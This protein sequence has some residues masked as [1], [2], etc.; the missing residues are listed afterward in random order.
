MKKKILLVIL[1]LILVASVIGA[2]KHD[3][4]QDI[5][6]NMQTQNISVNIGE[7][8]QLQNNLGNAVIWSS[9]NDVIVSVTDGGQIKGNK[10]GEA[11]VFATAGEKKVVYFVSVINNYSVSLAEVNL[12]INEDVVLSLNNNGA[13]L[14]NCLW[15]VADTAVATIDTQGKLTGRRDGTTEVLCSYQTMQFSI[16]VAVSSIQVLVPNFNILDKN[17]TVKTDNEIDLEYSLTYLDEPFDLPTAINVAYSQDNKCEITSNN[18]RLIVKGKQETATPLT[19]TISFL[20]KGIELKQTVS[21]DVIKHDVLIS[22]NETNIQTV[23]S[24]YNQEHIELGVDKVICDNVEVVN[25]VILWESENTYIAEVDN[26]GNVTIKNYGEIEILAKYNCEGKD[27]CAG[28]L[29]NILP[30]VTNYSFTDANATYDC[31]S[32]SN[33]SVVTGIVSDNLSQSKYALKVNTIAESNGGVIIDFE[34]VQ[35]KYVPYLVLNVRCAKNIDIFI[36]GGE[37]KV[38]TVDGDGTQYYGID[39][40]A[41]CDKE[42]ISNLNSLLL[43]CSEQTEIFIEK[44]DMS[45]YVYNYGVANAN[46]SDTVKT[47]SRNTQKVNPT[48]H[49]IVED[50]VS[51]TRYALK[52][53]SNTIAETDKYDNGLKIYFDDLE[54][55]NYK[56]IVLVVRTDG[57]RQGKT[58]GENLNFWTTISGKYVSGAYVKYSEDYLRIDL[59]ETCR[60]NGIGVLKNVELYQKTGSVDMFIHSVEFVAQDLESSYDFTV[61]GANTKAVKLYSEKNETVGTFGGIVDVGSTKAVM[62]STAKASN[63]GLQ[64]VFDKKIDTY[65][66]KVLLSIK[67]DNTS[68]GAITLYHSINKVYISA[69]KGITATEFNDIDI[70]SY[71][72]SRNIR[73]LK[74]IEIFLNNNWA[75]IYIEKVTIVERTSDDPYTVKFTGDQW[76]QKTTGL[77]VVNS[78]GTISAGQTAP[79]AKP[80]GV[81]YCVKYTDN[82]KTGGL[83]IDFGGIDLKDYASIKITFS[84]A[85]N[86]NLYANGMSSA[87]YLTWGN[88]NTLMTVDIVSLCNG[89]SIS[90]LDTFGIGKENSVAAVYLYSIE[91]TLK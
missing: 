33:N 82:T 71:S 26:N 90:T 20:W 7:I 55:S 41:I 19:A 8:K 9:N 35:L 4:T 86:Y 1:C 23:F 75:N 76:S 58:V 25:P 17:V 32:A 45:A 15:Q 30:S 68:G 16:P 38:Y 74:D 57:N 28:C 81:T 91:F 43:S 88:G 60:K 21:V 62:V 3:D 83:I 54:I 67:A 79:T 29:L 22:L 73:Y 80:D 65:K 70:S 56:S 64:F 52:I 36:N 49:G 11:K 84:T 78:V 51:P 2:C 12:H 24:K 72:L 37:S 39:I 89:K 48:D 5:S 47:F 69:L 46:Y 85:G 18:G 59:S 42:R 44:I 27:Y 50:I 53:T 87:N 14:A 31:V 40:K 34:N 77:S 66:Y 13:A 61:E 6:A 63:N 10:V